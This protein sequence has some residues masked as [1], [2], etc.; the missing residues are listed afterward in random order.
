MDN[1]VVTAALITM[2]ATMGS[3]IIGG[4]FYLWRKDPAGARNGVMNQVSKALLELAHVTERLN[5]AHDDYLRII[6]EQDKRNRE[7]HTAMMTAIEKLTDLV[8]PRYRPT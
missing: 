4:M 3:A 2:I 5:M 7:E 1:P 8:A 6:Q